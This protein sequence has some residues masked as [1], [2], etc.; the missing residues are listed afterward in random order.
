MG[1]MLWYTFESI[2]TPL[3]IAKNYCFGGLISPPNFQ[4]SY[5]N[6]IWKAF[7]I[8]NK[9]ARKGERVF[10]AMYSRSPLRADLLQ[11]LFAPDEILKMGLSG[12]EFTKPFTGNE[13]EYIYRSGGF[14]VVA[15]RITH[16]TFK[17]VSPLINL[18]RVPDF[19]NI[20]NY[21]IGEHLIVYQIV[22]KEGAPKPMK[23]SVEQ[24]DGTWKVQDLIN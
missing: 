17:A 6:E 14:W 5:Q 24:A 3:V 4:E 1:I 2:K 12:G 13:W 15:D 10:L 8:V 16:G 9:K 21:P 7:A 19:L 18:E 20:I 22:P 23:A 11:S